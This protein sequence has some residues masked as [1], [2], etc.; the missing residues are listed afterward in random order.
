MKKTRRVEV[1]FSEKEYDELS[2]IAG[3]GDTTVSD[4]VRRSA[5][6]VKTITLGAKRAQQESVREIA[7]IGNNLNQLTVMLRM[8]HIHNLN[9]EMIKEQFTRF[10]EVA[11]TALEGK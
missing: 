8:G 7:K 4:V 10:V 11:E 3:K 6:K 2:V 5:T 1:R 9:L